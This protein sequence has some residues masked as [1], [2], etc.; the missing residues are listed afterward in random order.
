ARL[1]LESRGFAERDA[2][3]RGPRLGVVLAV[4]PVV[5]AHAV[6]AA[7]R[8]VAAPVDQHPAGDRLPG[9]AAAVLCLEALDLARLPVGIA[10][11]EAEVEVD[12]RRRFRR[13]LSSSLHIR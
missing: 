5:L 8:I 12:D 6:L 4:R 3:M 10:A 1:D 7:E 13:R 2:V 11:A 9:D